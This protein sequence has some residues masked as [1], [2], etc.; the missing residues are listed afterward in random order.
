[1]LLFCFS[2]LLKTRFG[3]CFRLNCSTVMT[4]PSVIESE[5]PNVGFVDSKTSRKSPFD[6]SRDVLFIKMGNFA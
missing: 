3:K 2:F 5:Q 6:A 1:M 4:S